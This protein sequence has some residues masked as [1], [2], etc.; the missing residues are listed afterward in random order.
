MRRT[1][2]VGVVVLV[3]AFVGGGFWL[4]NR[5]LGDSPAASGPITA[6]TLP[7]Q[8]GALIF[9]IVPDK[10]EVRFTIPEDLRGK[11]NDVVGKSNQVAGQIA[12]NPDNLSAAHVGVIQI[13][14]R[15]FATDSGQRNRAINNFI[16]NTATYEFITLTPT[17]IRGLSGKA[18]LGKD[19]TFQ[20]AGDLTIRDVTKPVVFDVTARPTRRR[21]CPAALR[22]ASTA[23]TSSYKSPTC[24]LSPMLASRSRWRSI[25]W[26]R[27]RSSSAAWPF[28]L[29]FPCPL[30]Q[31]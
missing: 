4:Y 13:N 2:V 25:L 11:P 31:D 5:L 16:L 19:L 22:P 26:P 29:S 7:P 15:T 24:R 1:I 28:F 8:A 21:S 3:L 20:I 10:S 6:A 14:A 30:S 23:P 18:E 12:V 27:L 17:E 9:Q